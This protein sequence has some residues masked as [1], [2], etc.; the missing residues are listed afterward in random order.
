VAGGGLDAEVVCCFDPKIVIVRLK[1]AF[2]EVEVDPYDHAWRDYDIFQQMGAVE[3]AIKIA[4]RDAQRRGPLFTFRFPS[5]AL[6]VI[7]GRAER[8]HV[9][10]WSDEPIPEPL[11]S[12]F[13][14]FLE[15]LRFAA[16]VSVKSVRLEGNNEFPA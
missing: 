3:G 4:E 10:I 13:I 15:N 14:E 7:Q 16:C 5:S 9:A 11:R 2:P 12:R 1:R 6:A 8:Y